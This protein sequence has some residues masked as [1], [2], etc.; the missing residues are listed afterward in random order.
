[1][2]AQH[3]VILVEGLPGSGKTTTSQLLVSEYRRRGTRYVWAREEATDHPF[4]GPG[5][6]RLH[7]Q[8]DYDEI[9]LAQWR[10]LVDHRA[11]TRWVLDGCAMQ[12]AVRFMFEQDWTMDRVESYWRRFE[13]IIGCVRVALVYFWHPKPYAFIQDHAI[14]VRGD[15]WPKI[16]EHVEQTP[17]GRQLAEA[18]FDAPIEFWVEYGKMCERLLARSALPVLRVDTSRGWS[19]V[20]TRA[21]AWL[22]ALEMGSN[23][24]AA[25]TWRS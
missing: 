14:R 20:A 7:Q 2:Q 21:T 23:E 15:D 11:P 18:G 17:A 13:Q 1:M 3:E 22:A 8:A 19:D 24:T 4:F 6:R 5:V 9:C 25:P 12:S 16:A 10:L